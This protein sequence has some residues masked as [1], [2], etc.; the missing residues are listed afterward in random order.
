MSTSDTERD[1]ESTQFPESTEPLPSTS[2]TITQPEASSSVS[3]YMHTSYPQQNPPGYNYSPSGYYCSLGAYQE[4]PINFNRPDFTHP[5]TKAQEL[6]NIFCLND[7]M[8]HVARRAFD[9]GWISKAETKRIFHRGL[10]ET[11]DAYQKG[12]LASHYVNNMINYGKF[13]KYL[14]RS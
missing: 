14:S 2:S 6:Y 11:F 10:T 12:Y 1:L 8:N 4:C 5:P 9:K 7:H 3:S 13:Y